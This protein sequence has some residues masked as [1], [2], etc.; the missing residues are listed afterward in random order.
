MKKF[1]SLISLFMLICVSVLGCKEKEPENIVSERQIDVN[2]LITEGKIV[3]VSTEEEA[4]EKTAEEIPE[5]QFITFECMNEIKEASPESGMLQIYDMLFQ[6]GCTVSE[7]MEIVEN[8]QNTFV[9]YREYNENELILPGDYSEQIIFT[10]NDEWYFQFKAQNIT[11]ETIS[12]KDCIIT[13][14]TSETGSQGNAFIGGYDGNEPFTYDYVK[15][16]LMKDYETN[17]RKSTYGQKKYIVLQYNV[18]E[19]ETLWLT[20]LIDPETGEVAKISID[21]NKMY[22]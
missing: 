15:N 5:V 8:S 14:I 21:K 16:T 2:T 13:N 18:L 10:Y 17:E 1:I 9:L 20:F 4:T 3:E 22:F 12:L 19:K 7:A 6:Y 11:E